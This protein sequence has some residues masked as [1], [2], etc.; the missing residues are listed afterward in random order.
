MFMGDSVGGI[1]E[2]EEEKKN[3]NESSIHGV[4][5]TK[6]KVGITAPENL[7]DF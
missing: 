7:M 4:T 1:M 5:K 3:D 2:K 6:N